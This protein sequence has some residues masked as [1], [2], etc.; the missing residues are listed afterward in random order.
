[1]IMTTHRISFLHEVLIQTP[2]L[3]IVQQNVPCGISRVH[4][5]DFERAFA[6]S[7]SKNLID[8]MLI[9]HG[10][11]TN[12]DSTESTSDCQQGNRTEKSEQ[13]LELNLI[14]WDCLRVSMIDKMESITICV[15]RLD[16]HTTVQ[17]LVLRNTGFDVRRIGDDEPVGLWMGIVATA[18][19]TSR[20]IWIPIS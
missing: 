20:I 17:V 11:A 12:L 19:M 9:K 1:M 13:M 14:G 4:E 2:S 8:C 15:V 5:V 16:V 10:L 3:I 6:Q 18:S 7:S